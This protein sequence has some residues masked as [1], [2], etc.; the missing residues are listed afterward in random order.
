MGE[1]WVG[2]ET[3]FSL[4]AS[5]YPLSAATCTDIIYSKIHHIKRQKAREENVAFVFFAVY[6][7]C[8]PKTACSSEH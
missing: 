1:G 2:K 4:Y 3:D 6:H 7:A 8:P 5:L